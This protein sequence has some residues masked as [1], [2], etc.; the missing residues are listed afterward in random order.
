[1][2]MP[3]MAFPVASYYR[4]YTRKPDVA[5]N[6][7]PPRPHQETNW[8]SL[9]AFAVAEVIRSDVPGVL[10]GIGL[11]EPQQ[12]F[13]RLAGVE[14]ERLHLLVGNPAQAAVLQQW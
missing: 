13:H 14:H 10:L 12:F 7:R 5:D 6:R 4:Q 11:L 2:T 3:T 9:P 8:S 1:M